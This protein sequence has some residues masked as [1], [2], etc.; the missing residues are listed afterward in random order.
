MGMSYGR[1]FDLRVVPLSEVGEADVVGFTDDLKAEPRVF[2]AA[3]VG[4]PSA[5]WCS[6]LVHPSRPMGVAA[7]VGVELAGVARFTRLTATGRELY[8]AVA[9]PY[10]RLGIATELLREARDLAGERA[11]EAVLM[12]DEP[13]RTVRS[14]AERFRPQPSAAG[15]LAVQGRVA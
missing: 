4:R 10:R 12:A 13:R 6:M 2:S 9:A 8:I 14:L 15:L 11:E 7:L 3:A 5:R 1:T